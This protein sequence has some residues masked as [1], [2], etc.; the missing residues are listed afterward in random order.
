MLSSVSVLNC[1][2]LIGG[3]LVKLI[4]LTPEPNSWR[5]AQGEQYKMGLN[6]KSGLGPHLSNEHETSQNQTAHLSLGAPS[7]HMLSLCGQKEMR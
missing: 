3:N 2:L 5:E 4:S 6:R 1:K 7:V